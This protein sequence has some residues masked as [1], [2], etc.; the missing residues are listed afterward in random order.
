MPDYIDPPGQHRHRCPECGLIWTHSD[1]LAVK[2]PECP[3]CGEVHWPRYEGPL[4]PTHNT[5]AKVA[6]DQ[7]SE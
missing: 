1:V 6:T 7:R 3:Y 5:A 2:T 4:P